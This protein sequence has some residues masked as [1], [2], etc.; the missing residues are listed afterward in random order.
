MSEPRI[1]TPR[2]SMGSIIECASHVREPPVSPRALHAAE[3]AAGEI[4]KQADDNP[5]DVK[6][7]ERYTVPCR[8]RAGIVD[9]TNRRDH[10]ALQERQ[11]HRENVSD[12]NVCNVEEQGHA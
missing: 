1:L 9:D 3:L 7:T 2:A 10:V 11:A 4:Q 12:E 5:C 8:N 6:A